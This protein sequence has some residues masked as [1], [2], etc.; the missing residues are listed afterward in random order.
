MK[1]QNPKSL[2]AST[3]STNHKMCKFKQTKIGLSAHKVQAGIIPEEWE[4]KSIN[5]VANEQKAHPQCKNI[6]IKLSGCYY[7]GINS[8]IHCK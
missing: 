5:E 8:K 3:N 4:V 2:S 7:G 1:P 6:I